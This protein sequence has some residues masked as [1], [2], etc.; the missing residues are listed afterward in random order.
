MILNGGWV[1]NQN[2]DAWLAFVF[3]LKKYFKFRTDLG[4]TLD[5][6]HDLFLVSYTKPFTQQIFKRTNDFLC[7][8]R[9][10]RELKRVRL[11]PWQQVIFSQSSDT[12]PER[13]PSMCSSEE[14]SLIDEM[15]GALSIILRCLATATLQL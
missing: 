10:I 6:Y 3:L 15:P 1:F 2:N 7:L 8:R 11:F 13:Q 4:Q 9:V 14:A 5:C 12:I